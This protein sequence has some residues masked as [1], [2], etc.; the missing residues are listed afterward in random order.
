MAD[1]IL[2]TSALPYANG[3]IH[4]GNVLEYVQTDIYV[5]FLRSCGRD[6]VY[7]CADDTHGTPIEI[8]AAK[9]GLK[10]EEFVARYFE[11]HQRDFRDFHIIL[12]FICSTH[13]ADINKYSTLIYNL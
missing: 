3:S 5:R 11:E 8:N 2:I 7:F 4:L 1:K 9:Q 6:V 10:P 12:D 13:S